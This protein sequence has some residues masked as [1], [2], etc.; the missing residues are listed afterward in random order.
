MQISQM[1]TDKTLR[2]TYFLIWLE[3]QANPPISVPINIKPRLNRLKIKIN[4]QNKH[5][6]IKTA[7]YIKNVLPFRNN[8]N[9]LYVCF[10]VGSKKVRIYICMYDN[11][12]DDILINGKNYVYFMGHKTRIIA[13]NYKVLIRFCCQ[14]QIS[15]YMLLVL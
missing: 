12:D 9:I 14:R 3:R 4:E 1:F 7:I 8:R 15:N 2:A 10:Q 13:T 6:V 11:N 5:E